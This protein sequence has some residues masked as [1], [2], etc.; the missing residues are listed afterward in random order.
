MAT[1]TIDSSIFCYGYFNT[2]NTILSVMTKT[3]DFVI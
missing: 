3:M 2:S 1:I